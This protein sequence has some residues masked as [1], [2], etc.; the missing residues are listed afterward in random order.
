MGFRTYPCLARRG[1]MAQIATRQNS[2][3][4]GGYNGYLDIGHQIAFQGFDKVIIVT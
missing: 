3:L 4:I 1:Q 2:Y